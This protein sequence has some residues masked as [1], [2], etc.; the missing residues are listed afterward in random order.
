M[1]AAS[2][3]ATARPGIH[4]AMREGRSADSAPLSELKAKL[5]IKGLNF[6]YGGFHALK[7]ITMDIQ[8]AR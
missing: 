7:N 6:Y 3:A 2:S 1:E 8:S 5:R 4:T